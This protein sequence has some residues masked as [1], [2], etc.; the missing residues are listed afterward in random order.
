LHA[1]RSSFK[2]ADGLSLEASGTLK[3]KIYEVLPGKSNRDFEARISI[4]LPSWVSFS[5]SDFV[6]IRGIPEESSKAR[7]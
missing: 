7:V 6:H 3:Q 1:N 2:R 5:I 4:Y